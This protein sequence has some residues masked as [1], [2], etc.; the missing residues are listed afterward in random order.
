MDKNDL[1][2]MYEVLAKAYSETSYYATNPKRI[3]LEAKLQE[4]QDKIEKL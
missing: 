3:W 4:L 1:I 2:K